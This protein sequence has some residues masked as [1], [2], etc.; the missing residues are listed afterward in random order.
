MIQEIFGVNAGIRRKCDKLAEEGYLAVAPD[1]FW[2]LEP[3]IELDPDVE[4]EFQKALD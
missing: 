1:L 3:G 2:Q 4:P